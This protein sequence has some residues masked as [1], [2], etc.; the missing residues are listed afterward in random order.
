MAQRTIAQLERNARRVLEDFERVVGELSQAGEQQACAV[1]TLLH[2][3]AD[4]ARDQLIDLEEGAVARAR[5][6]GR[7]AR[8]YAKH[9]PWTASGVALAA[10]ITFGLLAWRRRH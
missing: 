7:H 8:T 1:A 6:L 3:G 10:A 2:N 5:S 9:H 4:T